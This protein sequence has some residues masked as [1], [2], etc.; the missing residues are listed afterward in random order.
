MQKVKT[1]NHWRVLSIGSGRFQAW[2]DK[3]YE[4]WPVGRFTSRE[5]AVAKCN[6]MNAKSASQQAK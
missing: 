1:Q 5:L 2:N 4:S 6:E 3:T